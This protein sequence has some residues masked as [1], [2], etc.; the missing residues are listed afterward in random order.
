MVK[1]KLNL[2]TGVSVDRS[3]I[4]CFKVDGVV[5]AVF[6]A[7]SIGSMGLPIILVSK[8]ENN[9]L[10]KIANAD[11]WTK[12]KGYLKEII[13]GVKKESVKLENVVDADEIYYTQLTLP[14]ASF[15]ALK[16]SYNENIVEDNSVNLNGIDSNQQ[17]NSAP[18]QE[19]P[20]PNNVNATISP[21]ET[22]VQQTPSE[23][24]LPNVEVNSQ[25][26]SNLSPSN[27]GIND[28][29]IVGLNPNANIQDNLNSPVV[30]NENPI[31]NEEKIIENPLVSDSSNLNSVQSI[32]SSDV[33]VAN[34]LLNDN[35]L[36]VLE[37]PKEQATNDVSKPE[38][39][40]IAQSEPSISNS[41]I[42]N[43][44]MS[45]NTKDDFSDE[46]EEFLKFWSEFFDKMIEKIKNN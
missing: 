13:S 16:N 7:A 25:T 17:V 20:I 23:P 37:L 24:E 39:D 12:V 33:P 44:E 1:I 43:V 46:K 42:S 36:P 4:N 9:R 2:P 40:N 22:P 29:Q 15:D 14:V 10:V 35:S 27:N 32:P 41:N 26:E 38:I 6:D 11:E 45:N 19:V 21:I 30:T 18:T 31:L 34:S 3:L 5:Y 8:F 28:A